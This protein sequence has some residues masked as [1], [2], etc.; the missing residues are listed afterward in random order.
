MLLQQGWFRRK[1]ESRWKAMLL[2]VLMGAFAL[3]MIS[4][5]LWMLSASLQNQA[6]IFQTPFHW[7]PGHLVLANYVDAWTQGNLGSAFLMSVEV[8]LLYIPVHVFLSSLTGY[9]FAKFHFRGRNL[10]FL[11]ILI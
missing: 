8:V 7:I 3:L 9:V 11:F 10:L 2:F 6:E 1:K 5:V 4:P